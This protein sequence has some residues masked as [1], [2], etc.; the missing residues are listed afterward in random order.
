MVDGWYYGE[1]TTASQGENRLLEIL[2]AF[3]F[4]LPMWNSLAAHELIVLFEGFFRFS[5]RLCIRM[6]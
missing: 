3:R 5:R 1:S 2:M 6:T 4:V